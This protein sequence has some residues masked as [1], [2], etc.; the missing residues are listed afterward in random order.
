MA[1]HEI[2]QKDL[3]ED[4]DVLHEICDIHEGSDD[5]FVRVL[6]AVAHEKHGNLAYDKRAG[7]IVR[8][9]L[10][11]QARQRSTGGEQDG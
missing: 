1:E 10:R 11:D 3:Y 6:E 9:W 2:D 8:R 5:R 7:E 4:L